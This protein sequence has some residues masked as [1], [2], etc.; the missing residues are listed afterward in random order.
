MDRALSRLYFY[1][2]QIGAGGKL[3]D[4]ALSRLYL[5]RNK[6]GAEGAG[7]AGVLPQWPWQLL[8]LSV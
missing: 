7:L 5:Y 1:K 6:I 8:R 3:L 2:N 4:Q